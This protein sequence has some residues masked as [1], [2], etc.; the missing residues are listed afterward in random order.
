MD[1]KLP[2][3]DAPDD[4][5]PEPGAIHGRRQIRIEL[6]GPLGCLA[7]ALVLAAAL[8]I[9]LVAAFAGLIAIA[10]A[11][12]IGAAFLA[13]AIIAALIRGRLR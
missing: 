9:L 7:G 8:S 13:V 11:F 4:E 5:L 2:R 6:K 1:D 10:V 12:W 3:K